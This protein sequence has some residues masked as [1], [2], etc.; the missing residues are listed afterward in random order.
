MRRIVAAICVM[1]AAGGA[2]WYFFVR[3]W[4]PPVRPPLH[5]ARLTEAQM[6]HCADPRM[7]LP[8]AGSALWCATTHAAWRQL[9]A[10]LHEP[11][12]V[13]AKQP[14]LSGWL[15]AAED[16]AAYVPP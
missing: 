8:M 10:Q 12:P 4:K 15:N 14:E 6:K 3:D 13:L 2:A 7:P 16:P 1:L 9:P 5:L 11:S